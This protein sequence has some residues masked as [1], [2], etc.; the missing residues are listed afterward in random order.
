M[1]KIV[2]AR[3]IALSAVPFLLPYGRAQSTPKLNN[4]IVSGEGF[5]FG[6]REPVGWHGDTGA[7]ASQY[8]VNVVF[9]P[10]GELGDSVATIRVRVNKKVD[11]NTIEDLNYDLDGYR[12]EFPTAQFQDLNV[13]H[14][15][16]KTFSKLVF[17]PDKF[18]E[19]IAYLNPGDGRRF[20]FSV[21]MS[22]GKRPASEE[23]L[24]AFE[25]VLSSL[26][27]LSG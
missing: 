3:W 8:H 12:K 10:A 25:G 19:Y 16:F 13:A 5:A 7:I 14:A 20:I 22:T 23:E 18:Y 6:V 2:N 15:E 4:L 27:W 26:K 24:K 9:S 11:E 1:S 17:I 21:A